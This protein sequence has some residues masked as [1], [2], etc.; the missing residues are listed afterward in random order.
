MPAGPMVVEVE[1][2]YPHHHGVEAYMPSWVYARNI[3]LSKR[4]VRHE[5]SV[6]EN[7][8]YEEF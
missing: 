2:H 5:L 1:R 4:I 3:I 7:E 6:I 8:T